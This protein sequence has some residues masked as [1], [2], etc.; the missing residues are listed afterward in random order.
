MSGRLAGR[1]AIVTGAGRGIGAAIVARLMADGAQ[2][3]AVDLSAEAAAESGATLALAC[4]VADSA[5]VAAA[6]KAAR[7]A[8]GRLDIAVANAGIGQAPNDGS[9]QFYGAMARRNAE[10]AESGKSEVIVDQLIHMEDAGWAAVLAV[11]LN[12]TFYLCREFA[13]VLAEDGNPGSIVVLSSTSAQSGEGSAHYCASKAA[14]IGLT[15]QLARELAPRRIRINAVAPGPTNTPVMQGIPAEWIASMEASVPL[16]RM[17]DPAEIAASVAFLAS[18][19]ASYV[20]GSVLVA[21]G[22]SYFF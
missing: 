13:R 4:N 11:N 20:N 18:D 5:S 17:A 22:A 9:E 16:G 12:G 10:L 2:V 8:F 7:E 6:V 3:A 14:V 21:N 15:R 19:E 1:A